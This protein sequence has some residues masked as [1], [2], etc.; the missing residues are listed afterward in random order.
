MEP[1]TRMQVGPRSFVVRWRV[2]T[3]GDL[4]LSDLLAALSVATDLGMGQPPEKAVRSCLLATAA[5]GRHVAGSGGAHH[6]GQGA[7][8]EHQ[9]GRDPGHGGGVHRSR[10]RRRRRRPG[11][12]SS[13]VPAVEPSGDLVL[14][15]TGELEDGEGVAGQHGVLLGFGASARPLDP[16]PHTGRLAPDC[17][18]STPRLLDVQPPLLGQTRQKRSPRTPMRHQTT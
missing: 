8:R 9:R 3:H 10:R 13:T 18:P 14:A 12:A 6:H 4:R 17:R 16:D 15:L 1:A 5:V 2:G 7:A 11:P